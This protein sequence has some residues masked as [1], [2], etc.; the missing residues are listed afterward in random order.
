MQHA[1]VSS[2]LC[3]IQ[4]LERAAPLDQA[5]GVLNMASSAA[6]Q[7]RQGKHEKAREVMM[8]EFDRQRQ[9]IVKDTEGNRTAADRFVG[10]NDS[11]EE[12]LKKQTVGLVR[13]EDFQKRREE[14]EEEKRR[15]AAKTNELK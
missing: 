14:L 9:D 4:L 2:P 6:E 12:T 1:P 13:L 7:R 5:I 10:K 11:I 8:A 15:E 3:F